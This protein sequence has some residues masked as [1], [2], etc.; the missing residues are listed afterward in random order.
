M[1]TSYKF[2]ILSTFPNGMN[3]RIL[4]TTILA[5]LPFIDIEYLSDGTIGFIFASELD[6]SQ[7]TTL[8]TLFSQHIPYDSTITNIVIINAM[9]TR[10]NNINY[11]R[12]CIYEYNVDYIGLLKN[13]KILCNLNFTGTAYFRVYNLNTNTV[14]RETQ[15][16]NIV[17]TEISLLNLTDF[18]NLNNAIIELHAK[19]T[20]DNILYISSINACF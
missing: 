9:L 19:V 3:I 10:I 17:E 14:V 2:N 1:T 11:T 18:L 16:N 20:N 4:A 7:L 5:V 15:I 12:I 8:N 6:S 13:I